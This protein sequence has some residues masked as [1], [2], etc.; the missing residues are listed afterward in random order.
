M[1]WYFNT[2]GIFLSRSTFNDAYRPLQEIL[3]EVSK[4]GRK[5]VL[6]KGPY[7]KEANIG[8]GKCD[9]YE[10]VRG[11]CS[12]LRSALTRDVESRREAPIWSLKL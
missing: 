8:E 11:A 12:K 2:G 1:T 7:L 3:T 9:I 4:L 10:A 5:G 6:P